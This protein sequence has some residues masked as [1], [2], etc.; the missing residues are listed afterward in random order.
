MIA[1]LVLTVGMLGGMLIITVAAASNAQAR[2]DTAAVALAQST[3]DRLI[4]ISNTTV[5]AAQ[6]TSMTDCDSTTLLS[7]TASIGGA[8]L[9]NTGAID[10]SQAA[11]SVPAGYQM[12]YTLCAAGPGNALTGIPQTYDVRWNIQAGPTTATQLVM[13]AAKPKGQIGNGQTQVRFFALPT[14]LR[15]L[16][17]N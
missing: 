4:V 17:G 3:M 12:D 8:Q 14:T 9:T 7:M 2:F 11:A 1:M 16:R 13:V 5:A 15:A 10:F 6:T